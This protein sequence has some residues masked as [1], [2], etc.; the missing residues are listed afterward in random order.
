MT[1]RQNASCKCKWGLPALTALSLLQAQSLCKRNQG[2][3]SGFRANSRACPSRFTISAAPFGVPPAALQAPVV[4]EKPCKYEVLAVC[5]PARS[6]R[7]FAAVHHFQVVHF[8]T[9][10]YF[11]SI[12]FESSSMA[13]SMGGCNIHYS[14]Y[15]NKTETDY[16][17]NLLDIIRADYNLK[18]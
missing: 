16:K 5:W 9:H 3:L 2:R 4:T 11:G 1:N 6:T 12:K 13:S 15:N 14:L 7:A 18:H 10:D 8:I 17:W